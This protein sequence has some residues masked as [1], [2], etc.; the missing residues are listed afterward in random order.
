MRVKTYIGLLS[1]G[2]L[3]GAFLIGIFGWWMLASNAKSI[4]N[5]KKKAETLE[6]VQ[7]STGM[8]WPF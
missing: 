2:G 1:A 3:E 8:Y 7:L 4:E 5:L 6:Q